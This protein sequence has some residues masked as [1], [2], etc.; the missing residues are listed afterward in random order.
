MPI[1]TTTEITTID[2][3]LEGVE[4]NFNFE[5]IKGEGE[6]FFPITSGD[7]YYGTLIECLEKPE[8]FYVFDEP[9]RP[10]LPRDGK[11][12]LSFREAFLSLIAGYDMDITAVSDLRLVRTRTVTSVETTAQ[13][14]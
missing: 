10:H 8:H 5:Y 14:L 9:Y 13:P 7:D 1:E 3:V 6:N 4:Y 2:F 12:A 11:E